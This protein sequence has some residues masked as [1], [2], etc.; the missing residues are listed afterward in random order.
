MYEYTN[1]FY[2]CRLFS[3]Q[4][5]CSTAHS[6]HSLP[7]GSRRLPFQGCPIQGWFTLPALTWPESSETSPRLQWTSAL[8]L[9]L[10]WFLASP[11]LLLNYSA[12]QLE[13]RSRENSLRFT[14]EVLL[15]FFFLPP[16]CWPISGLHLSSRQTKK[17]RE[18]F[19][20]LLS[21]LHK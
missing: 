1:N 9:L 4:N 21:M 18:K 17:T 7:L 3:A 11:C 10:A 16:C 6:S 5:I 2:I 14:S 12:L 15:C 19:K 8:G 13:E 20:Q